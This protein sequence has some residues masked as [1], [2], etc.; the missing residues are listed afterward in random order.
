MAV[1]N[2]EDVAIL[3][4]EGKTIFARIINRSRPEGIDAE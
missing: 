1:I 2:Q 4:R 3:I